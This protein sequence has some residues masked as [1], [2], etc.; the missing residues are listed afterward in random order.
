MVIEC[1]VAISLLSAQPAKVVKKKAVPQR[2]KESKITMGLEAG[3]AFPSGIG[4]APGFEV[5]G[6]YQFGLNG[7]MA[8][9]FGL[10]TGLYS[11]SDRGSGVEERVGGEYSYRVNLLT[12]PV[13]I[14]SILLI[15]TETKLKPFG[16][17]GLGGSWVKAEERAFGFT[18]SESKFVPSFRVSAGVEYPLGPGELVSLFRYS[19]S[20]VNFLST[21]SENSTGIGI[22]IGYLFRF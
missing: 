2:G 3:L 18:N 12:I 17:V 8:L 20:K 7:S 9:R 11:G 1:L 4:V 14:D 6:G 16:G 5:K 10:S 13:I 21:G 19:Y 15:R 22:Y